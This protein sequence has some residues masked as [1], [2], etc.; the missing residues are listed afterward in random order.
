MLYP[1]WANPTGSEMGQWRGSRHPNQT[2]PKRSKTNIGYDDQK[3]SP[4]LTTS[5]YGKT[6]ILSEAFTAWRTNEIKLKTDELMGDLNFERRKS[7]NDPVRWNPLPLG[8]LNQKLAFSGFHFSYAQSGISRR[9]TGDWSHNPTKIHGKWFTE[10]A[11]A[12]GITV[13]VTTHCGRAEYCSRVSIM[14]DGPHQALDSPAN[15]KSNTMPATW[16]EPAT[17]KKSQKRDWQLDNAQW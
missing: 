5:K 8:G 4:L 16:T 11:A 6:S 7:V 1:D 3:F 12:S 10:A 17:G 13:F 14:V 9:T 2:Q 15:L